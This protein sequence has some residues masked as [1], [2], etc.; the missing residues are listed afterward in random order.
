MPITRTEIATFKSRRG[1]PKKPEH[2]KLSHVAVMMPPELRLRVE[3]WAFQNK[4]TVSQII[5]AL[6]QDSLDKW[7]L[8]K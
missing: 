1:R 4:T 6:V 7:S 8:K 3:K 2:L 5:V